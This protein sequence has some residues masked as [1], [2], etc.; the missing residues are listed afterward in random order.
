MVY[1]TKEQVNAFEFSESLKGF[2]IIFTEE[3]F[4]SYF[5]NLTENFVFRLFNPQLFSPI[6]QIPSESDFE[7][8]FKLL[9]KEYNNS[10]SFNQKSIINSLFTILISKAENIKTTIT[11]IAKDANR[12]DNIKSYFGQTDARS[13]DYPNMDLKELQKGFVIIK[14]SNI[15]AA[16]TEL[17]IAD[18]DLFLMD[19]R[20][21]TN[22]F[23]IVS[24]LSKRAEAISF[25]LKPEM[26][27]NAKE[28]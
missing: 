12:W 22:R 3:Y 15:W 20:A 21:R 25:L 28:I 2:C 16:T 11:K 14:G 1:L 19:L 17:T 5:S 7:D 9:Q 8:Y 4:V 6:L 23:F 26:V 10:K 27:F 24:S 13:H 18:Y